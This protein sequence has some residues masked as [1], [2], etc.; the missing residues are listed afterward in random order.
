MTAQQI[1]RGSCLCGGIQYELHGTLG[2]IIQCHCQV[3]R[4]ASGTAFATNS[5][6]KVSDF[7]FTQGE[8]LLKKYQSS[9]G[10]ERCFCRDCGSP[11][12]SIKHDA[13][14]FYRLRVGSLDTP[15][16][17]KPSMHIFVKDKAEWDSINDDLPQY[18]S[19]P[20]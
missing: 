6:V 14:E 4:K 13:P 16:T 2:E 20:E 8:L 1:Y 11:L 19:R 7:K 17:E 5:P 18:S 10:A 9:S 12:L 15:I 3:C